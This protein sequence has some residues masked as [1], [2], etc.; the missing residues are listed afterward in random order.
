MYKFFIHSL[1][2]FIIFPF[3]IVFGQEVEDSLVTDVP[4]G[5]T[6]DKILSN[7]IKNNGGKRKIKKIKQ[8]SLTMTAPVEETK[9]VVRK[10]YKGNY[11]YM[12]ELKADKVVF[13]RYVIH[14]EKGYVFTATQVRELDYGEFKELQQEMNLYPELDYS[15]RGYFYELKGVE[16][17]AGKD[18]YR[19]EV[20][21]PTGR[22]ITEYY[23]TKNFLK[24]RSVEY[25][26]STNNIEATTD[27]QSYQNVK[28]LK[29]LR[30][31]Q[32]VQLTM[33]N[34]D[35]MK[36]KVA[37]NLDKRKLPSWLDFLRIDKWFFDENDYRI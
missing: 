20:F 12:K 32:N 18:A 31:P 10:V 26:D 5:I 33:D 36:F 29:G 25:K 28:K 7:Y 27:I 34:G 9:L 22:R 4:K 13:K 23:S 24:V 11:F 1:L 3:T 15:Q 35:R 16:N 6:P 14:G 21:T 8:L 19:M 2:F 17:I 37:Y 30:V